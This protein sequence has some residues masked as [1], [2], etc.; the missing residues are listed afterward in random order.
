[1]ADWPAFGRRGGSRRPCFG[2]KMSARGAICWTSAERTRSGW[3]GLPA[4][5]RL[6][7]GRRETTLARECRGRPPPFC[8]HRA[9][10]RPPGDR[11]ALPGSGHGPAFHLE[12]HSRRVVC[13]HARRESDGAGTPAEAEATALTALYGVPWTLVRIAGGR[14]S[15]TLAV[16]RRSVWPLRRRSPPRRRRCRPSWPSRTRRARRTR[17]P[18]RTRWP[19]GWRTFTVSPRMADVVSS[20]TARLLGARVASTAIF[21]PLT[22][23]LKVHGTFGYP[24]LLVEHARIRSR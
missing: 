19:A 13:R 18:R 6:R 5:K 20:A 2:R 7:C 15:V 21:D 14:R 17:G 1:M 16:S 22:Q 24:S 4:R 11:G 8:G 10:R 9:G 12:R 3:L 23:V